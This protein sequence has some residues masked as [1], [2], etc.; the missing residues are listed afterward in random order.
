[1]ALT[2][3]GAWVAKAGQHSG[4]KPTDAAEEVARL[5]SIGANPFARATGR[6]KM[7]S[8]A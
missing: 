5:Q 2:Q 7:S 1:M 6:E 3:F 4:D 8:K